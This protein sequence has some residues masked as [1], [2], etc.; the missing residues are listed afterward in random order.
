MSAGMVTVC[1]P[2]FAFSSSVAQYA[3]GASRSP[4]SKILN[5]GVDPS[6]VLA[7]ETLV[8]HKNRALDSEYSTF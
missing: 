6:A 3:V 4:L 8:L 7:S 1:S 5:H 2:Q